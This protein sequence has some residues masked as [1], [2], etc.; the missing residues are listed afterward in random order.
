MDKLKELVKDPAA[1]DAKIKEY[2]NIISKGEECVNLEDF[3][4]RSKEL[5]EKEGITPL[6]K[7]DEGAR[8]R[9]LK[10]IDPDNSGK[11]KFDGFEKYLKYSVEYYKK[12][13]TL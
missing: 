9:R 2:W 10:M 7:Y 3:K 13:G 6:V 8:E 1:L 5:A 11:V 4:V 12:D